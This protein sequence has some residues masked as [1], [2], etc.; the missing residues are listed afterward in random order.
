MKRTNT[1]TLM[2]ASLV[3]FAGLVGLA[4]QKPATQAPVDPLAPKSSAASATIGPLHTVTICT[5]DLESYLRLYRDGLGMAVKGPIPITDA[6]RTAQNALWGMK[7][8]A[9]RSTSWSAPRSGT[10]PG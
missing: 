10:P 9:G 4:Q 2:I 7:P 8:S 3:A 1:R 5:S 6:V